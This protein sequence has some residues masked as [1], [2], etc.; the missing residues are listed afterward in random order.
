MKN[1]GNCGDLLSPIILEGLGYGVE[2]AAPKEADFLLTGSIVSHA[3]RGIVVAGSGIGSVDEQPNKDAIYLAVRGPRTRDAVLKCGGKCPE[4]YG[5]PGLLMPHFYDKPVPKN[6]GPAVFAHYVDLE[7]LEFITSDLPIINPLGDPLAVIDHMRQFD[8]IFSSSLHGIILAHAYG[9]PAAW[10]KPSDKL[11]GDGVKFADYAASVGVT[12]T[13][14]KRIDDAVP[15]LPR[16]INVKPLLDIL[17]NLGDR[18]LH[19]KV[20]RIRRIWNPRIFAGCE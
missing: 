12:L 13:P 1:P 6:K 17:G 20:Q 15:V 11:F 10:V 8:T 5:D 9:I 14:Y 4:V 16:E 19:A 18:K 7:A 2:W 3:T